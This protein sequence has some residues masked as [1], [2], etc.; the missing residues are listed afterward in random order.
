MSKSFEKE[1][2]IEA[3]LAVAVD[4]AQALHKK[5]SIWKKWWF[6]VLLSILIGI[7]ITVVLLVTAGDGTP[8]DLIDLPEKEYRKQC[9]TYA[10]D[11]F[12]R[13]PDA[14]EG[15]LVKL[16]GEV[17]QVIHD[18]DKLRMRVNVT[19][20]KEFDFY[21]DTVFVLYNMENGMNILEGDIV[22]MYGEL[23]G[24]YEYESVFKVPVSIPR[25]YVKFIYVDG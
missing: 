14:Y 4:E 25:V 19:H 18:G 23:R 2:E 1:S 9:K 6:W 17:I 11:D 20:N 7:G 24:L 10:Y 22:R 3:G 8:S 12:A 5:K 15:T 16:K 13:Y 21:E